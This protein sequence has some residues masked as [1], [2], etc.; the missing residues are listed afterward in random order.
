MRTRLS[1][2]VVLTLML[3]LCALLA[4]LSYSHIS[5]GFIP[6]NS[7]RETLDRRNLGST[8][9][10]GNARGVVLGEEVAT[11]SGIQTTKL[12][13]KE[14][15]GRQHEKVPEDMQL[16]GTLTRVGDD[17]IGDKQHP[18]ILDSQ[19]ADLQT[20]NAQ[21]PDVKNVTASD[22]RVPGN[23]SDVIKL[24]KQ[25]NGNSCVDYKSFHRCLPI[26]ALASVPGSGNTWM[27]FLLEEST[28]TYIC[29]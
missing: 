5:S 7:N 23:F 2:L 20:G 25:H 18:L 19:E 3:G 6:A 14:S 8:G 11:I 1:K 22:K 16:R 15:V 24:V 12:A 10:N 26:T 29:L 4:H 13:A 21:V 27:R 9:H 17:V 28:G